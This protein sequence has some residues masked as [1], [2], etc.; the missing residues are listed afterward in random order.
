M[1]SDWVVKKIDESEIMKVY[2]KKKLEIYMI[3]I[4]FGVIFYNNIISFM[5]Y[6]ML[7]IVFLFR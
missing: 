2:H 6:V 3:N 7:Q 5:F 1:C 4:Q